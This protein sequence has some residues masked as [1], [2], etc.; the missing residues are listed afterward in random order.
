[1]EAS[2]EEKYPQFVKDP[3]VSFQCTDPLSSPVSVASYGKQNNGLPNM[4]FLS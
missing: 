2:G 1:M 4:I 3:D